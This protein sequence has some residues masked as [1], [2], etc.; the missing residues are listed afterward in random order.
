MVRPRGRSVPEDVVIKAL[1]RTHGNISNTAKF[2]QVSR[3]ALSSRINATPSLKKALDEIL[4]VSLDVAEDHLFRAI[5]ND[6][7]TAIIFFLKTRGKS[8]GY[9]ERTEVKTVADDDINR[10][11]DAEL[12]KLAA[13]AP[14]RSP[15]SVN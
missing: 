3:P 5:E 6:N 7:M 10:A 15:A 1:Q 14:A 13:V 8:R 12:A 4:D 9:I 11:I 2:L